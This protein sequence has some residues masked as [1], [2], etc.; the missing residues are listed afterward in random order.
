MSDKRLME[1]DGRDIKNILCTPYTLTI[2]IYYETILYTFS[3][4]N[5]IR[6]I[7]TAMDRAEA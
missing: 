4:S 2:F 1:L 3:F 6:I 7:W 5:R